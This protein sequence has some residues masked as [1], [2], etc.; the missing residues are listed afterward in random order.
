MCISVKQLSTAVFFVHAG[1]GM[2]K[3]CLVSFAF[4][5]MFTF[6]VQENHLPPSVVERDEGGEKERRKPC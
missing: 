1:W 6:S 5:L 3:D 4:C 2:E